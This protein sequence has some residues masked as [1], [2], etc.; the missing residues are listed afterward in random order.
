MAT[1]ISEICWLTQLLQD[2]GVSHSSSALLFYD[3]Q[4]VVRIATNPIFHEC[5]KHFEI[6]CHFVR[7]QVAVDCIKLMPI[8]S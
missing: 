7:D 5:T 3:N 8:R 1:T 6:D 2:F 4:A